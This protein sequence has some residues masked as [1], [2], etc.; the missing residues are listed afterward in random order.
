MIGN[1][2]SQV[3]ASRAI[4]RQQA[5]TRENTHDRSECCWGEC[6]CRS[7][8]CARSDAEHEEKAGNKEWATVCESVN[9]GV[10]TKHTAAQSGQKVVEHNKGICRRTGLSQGICVCELE[11]WTG[12]KQKAQI[13]QPGRNPP[14]QTEEGEEGN[15]HRLK[16]KVLL[17]NFNN[18]TFPV[19]C[20]WSQ[21]PNKLL[22]KKTY[23]NLIMHNKSLSEAFTV[24]I[25]KICKCNVH[26]YCVSVAVF[27][28]PETETERDRG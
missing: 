18:I 20:V 2:N 28:Q 14:V 8:A 17:L 25:N 12:G 23:L 10:R 13:M 9:R 19:S 1:T 26:L 5:G 6:W 21:N 22:M 11:S 15:P 4:G 27:Q 7:G 16:W 24:Q 3:Q